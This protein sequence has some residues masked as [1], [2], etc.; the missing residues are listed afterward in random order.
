MSKI[1]AC[2]GPIGEDPYCPCKMKQEGLTPT[3][4]WTPEKKAELESA[5]SRMFNWKP[6]VEKEVT[7][8][9]NI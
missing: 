8:D 5:L 6:E 7:P 3:E 1:C 2:M 4:L 9:D